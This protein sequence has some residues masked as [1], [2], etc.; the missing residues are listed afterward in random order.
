MNTII[1]SK[2]DKIESLI[3]E[4]KKYKINCKTTECSECPF[5]HKIGSENLM[6]IIKDEICWTNNP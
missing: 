2:I 5:N 6:E 4:C 1:K 3:E